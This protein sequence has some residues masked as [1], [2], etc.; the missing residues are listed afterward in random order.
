MKYFIFFV[1]I[2]VLYNQSLLAIDTKAEQAILVDY[3]T[4]EILFEKNPNEKI[5]PASMT[6]IMTVYV[7]FDRLQKTDLTINDTCLVSARAY[8][9]GGSRSFL[10]LETK[11]TINDLLRGIIIQ[12]GNDASVA[13]AECLAGTEDDFAKLMNIYAKELGLTNTNFIN[14]SGWPNENHYSTVKDLVILSN[15]LIK[16]FPTLYAYFKET[17]FTYNNIKQP[18]RNR[19]LYNF[20]GA[21]GLKTGY[22][23]ASGWGISASAKKNDRRITLVIN[24]TKSSRSRL[25]ESTNLLNW[26][27]T[28]T[29]ER[30]LLKKN[31]VIKNVDVW[32]GNKP[33]VNLIVKEDVISI[34]SFDQIKSIKSLIEFEKPISAPIKLGEE[35]GKLIIDI[36]GKSKK[37]IPLVAENDVNNINP[38]MRVLAAIKYLIFGT[39]LDEI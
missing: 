16:S 4:S 17:E 5:Q 38:I 14:S 15:K 35:V 7:V 11:V 26:A 20:S 1:L 37:I 12:S 13:I 23:K 25:T 3:N 30:I 8:K 36:P 21:D 19:L 39:S 28:Q 27:F 18:N 31:Q 9:M 22:V 24:G 34:L 10:E 2:S 6:K 33:S 32:L 29:S